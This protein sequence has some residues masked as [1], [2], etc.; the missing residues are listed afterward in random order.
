LIR[1]GRIEDGIAILQSAA[2][3]KKR[4]AARRG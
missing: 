1:A 4:G 2:R 3:E